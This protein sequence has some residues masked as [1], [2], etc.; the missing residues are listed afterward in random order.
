MELTPTLRLYKR[1]ENGLKGTEIVSADGNPV[2]LNLGEKV[3][4]EFWR[5]LIR[6]KNMDVSVNMTRSVVCCQEKGYQKAY[7]RGNIRI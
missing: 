1:Q 4:M 3:R 6:C 5:I 2:K 7:R